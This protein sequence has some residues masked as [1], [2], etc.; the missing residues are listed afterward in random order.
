M[1]A[2]DKKWREKVVDH[3]KSLRKFF[4]Y[5][6]VSDN[7]QQGSAYTVEV[8]AEENNTG[9]YMW[10]E[11]KQNKLPF[12]SSLPGS[13]FWLFSFPWR[14]SGESQLRRDRV[15][16]NPWYNSLFISEASLLTKVQVKHSKG[17]T[18]ERGPF[19]TPLHSCPEVKYGRRATF[20]SVWF[21]RFGLVRQTTSNSAGSVALC[22]VGA[23][24]DSYG[25]LLMCRT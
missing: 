17:L 10:N 21:G 8:I 14:K 22:D 15:Q 3:T 16:E 5:F 4:S 19:Q 13:L 7:F 2:N 25:V 18:A 6:L 24:A 1:L 23:A 20:E 12:H 9:W 11:K